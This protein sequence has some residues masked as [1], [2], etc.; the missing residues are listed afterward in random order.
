MGMIIP[1]TETEAEEKHVTKKKLMEDLPGY[2][3][4]V[5][6]HKRGKRVTQGGRVTRDVGKD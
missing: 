1:V 4:W 6:R 3:F 5:V 2:P